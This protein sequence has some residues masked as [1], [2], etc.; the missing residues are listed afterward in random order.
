MH[1][2][3]TGGAGFI[4]SHLADAL[5]NRGDSV[6]VLDNLSTGSAE[7]IRSFLGHPRFSFT[8]AALDDGSA[9][10]GL[11][12]RADAIVHL[13]AAVGVHLILERPTQTIET[14]VLGTHALLAAARRHGC[15][16][17]IASTSEVYGKSEALPFSEND[18]L[19]LGPPDRTRW[20]YAATKLLDEFLALAAH[21]EFGLPL[22][23]MRLF[24]VV[25]PRQTGR[26][27]MVLP[28]FV[29]QALQGRPLTVYGDGMQTRCFCHVGDVV[30]A[31]AGLLGRTTASGQ[32]YNI[33]SNHEVTI[34]EL[35]E[36]T[37]DRADSRS[38]IHYLPY[39][40]A[41]AAGFEEL[42]R[43]VPEISKIADEIGWTPTHL[44]PE[45]LDD[46]ID[47]ERDRLT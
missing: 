18:D 19:I 21:Q 14:N 46:M 40:Q 31:I 29:R 6:S 7:N 20:V 34:R 44:L 37:V 11:A 12:S 47:F 27:G 41:Y 3:I 5:L 9:L 33:G 22:T 25:G 2:L 39:D 17:L 32:I 42:R 24:N 26:F 16:T 43:R 13:A 35:A 1:V 38:P 8:Q 23:I 10:D 36:L 15:Q 45:I 30:Q 28:R 4:G